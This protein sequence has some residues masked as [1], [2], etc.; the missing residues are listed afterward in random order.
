MNEMSEE[1]KAE[2]NTQTHRNGKIE[3][4]SEYCN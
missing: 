3:N 4:V 2:N 1:K